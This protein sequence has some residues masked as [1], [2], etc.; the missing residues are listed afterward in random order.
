[1]PS[2]KNIIA[3]YEGKER[4]LYSCPDNPYESIYISAKI[5]DGLLTVTDSECEHGPDGG[6]SHRTLAF[7]KVNTE[8]VIGILTEN[9]PDPFTA[10]KNMI[11]YH[12]RTRAF[13]NMCDSRGIVY[14]NTLSF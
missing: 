14:K 9:D 1:M 6:W 2:V 11:N 13:R 3:A 12:D 5:S 7:D 10:L 4:L 8:K